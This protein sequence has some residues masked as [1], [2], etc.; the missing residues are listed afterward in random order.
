MSFDQS[1]APS[2]SSNANDET[3]DPK[4]VGFARLEQAISGFAPLGNGYSAFGRV[5][6][7]YDHYGLKNYDASDVA[8]T[9]AL[10]K[11]WDT[12]VASLSY[13]QTHDHLRLMAD[14][15]ETTQVLVAGLR[16]ELK[17]APGWSV[18]PAFLLRRRWSQGPIGDTVGFQPSLAMS[19]STCSAQ[20]V[21]AC[22]SMGVTTRLRWSRY[23]QRFEGRQRIDVRTVG[24]AEASYQISP[25][26]RIGTTIT[27][28]V[29]R[30]NRPDRSYRTLDAAPV[31]VL[32]RVLYP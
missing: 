25:Q 24:V 8:A 2:F 3:R 18:T 12:V 14:H 19:Y 1:F 16:M 11:R 30:S 7:G 5:A 22:W 26:W 29:N 17:P 15:I 4:R 21:T 6:W 13:S 10:S 31:L 23:D 28:S 27:L 9:L 20:R 32:T